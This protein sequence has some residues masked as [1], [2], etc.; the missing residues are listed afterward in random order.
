MN[1]LCMRCFRYISPR[2][3]ACCA[4]EINKIN[5]KLIQAVNFDYVESWMTIFLMAG[6]TAAGGESFNGPMILYK[7]VFSFAWG[8]GTIPYFTALRQEFVATVR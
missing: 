4:I 6:D 1:L 3:D 2:D 5:I 8:T 7:L